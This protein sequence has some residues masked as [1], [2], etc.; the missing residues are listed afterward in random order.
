MLVLSR[1]PG[2][3][4]CIG[5]SITLDVVAVHGKQVNL[6]IACPWEIRILRSELV[7]RK[8]AESSTP[9]PIQRVRGES[10]AEQKTRHETRAG[11]APA[12]CT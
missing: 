2:E 5:D 12:P 8:P 6:A 11:R 9:I 1:K 4:I 7:E 3:R 10:H